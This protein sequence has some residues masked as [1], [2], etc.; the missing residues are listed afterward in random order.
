[1]SGIG[2]VF[3][4]RA[5]GN[6]RD[7]G[8]PRRL[9]RALGDHGVLA[10]PK[11]LDELSRAAED[12]HRQGI[13]VLG[14]AGGDGTNH[15]TLTGF[16]E[17]YGTTPLPTVAFLRGGTMNTVANA[18]GLPKGKPEGLLDRLVRRYLETP[19]LATVER[20]TLD[21]DGKLGFL[22]GIGVVSGFLKA[23]YETGAP[24]PWTA[25]KTLARGIGST[26][27][28]GPMVRRMTEPVE[29]EVET[30]GDGWG[31]RSYLTL[32]AG[33]IPDIGLGFRPFH[34]AD[35]LDGA[36][37]LLGIHTSPIGFVTELPRI[38]RAQA[39]MPG[40][41]S[42][43]AIRKATIRTRGNGMSM[44]IDGDLVELPRSSVKLSLGPSVRIATMQ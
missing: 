42:S 25:V 16:R 15:V 38:H 28:N 6:K 23:Y 2:L 30:E 5:G 43:L 20:R 12:F 27:V 40:K 9:A 22:W 21:I 39:M 26:I 29:A 1:M 44:M 35:E 8:A 34:L 14:I 37:H 19:D 36:F 7:P 13:T 33:T 41:A 18:L 32:A 31:Y 10:V 24:S 11:S 4:P 17:V 3:N